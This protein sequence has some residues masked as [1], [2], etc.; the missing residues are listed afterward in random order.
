M[1]AK[2]NA[3]QISVHIL[4]LMTLYWLVFNTLNVIYLKLSFI[5]NL[6]QSSTQYWFYWSYSGFYT[7]H[8]CKG[9]LFE[10][11][12]FWQK[13]CSWQR[14]C[15]YFMSEVQVIVP[16]KLI[17][18]IALFLLTQILLGTISHGKSSWT[19][20]YVLQK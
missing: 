16:L 6:F 1:P 10:E 13:N 14:C 11:I 5:I 20:C 19:S 17:T 12:S 4:Y 8:C 3:A 15:H 9:W 2:P 7:R 18:C